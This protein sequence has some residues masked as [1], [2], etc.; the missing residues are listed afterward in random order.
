MKS[1]S[2]GVRHDYKDSDSPERPPLIPFSMNR[3]GLHWFVLGLAI[4]LVAVSLML[5]SE[6]NESMVMDETDAELSPPRFELALLA[7]GA[8]T[9]LALPPP[10]NSTGVGQ[11]LRPEQ[12]ERNALLAQGELINLSVRNGDSLDRMFRRNNL[13]ISD[14]AEMVDLP[15]GGRN[16][17]RINPGDKLEI[18]RS[19]NRVL[20]LSRELS[21]SQRLWIKR[22]DE[23]FVA[24]V[25]DLE[26]ELRSAG[27]HGE[28]K[29]TL[30]EAAVEAGLNSAVIDLLA[31]TFEWDIDFSQEVRSGDSFTV[32][33]EEFW[34]DGVRMRTGN[35]IA[36]EYVNRGRTYRAAR[37]VDAEGNS[38]LFTPEGMNV[39][40]AFLRYPIDFTRISSNFNPNRR[41]PI[42]NTIRAHRGVDLAAATGTPVRAAGDGR[43]VARG[44]NGSYGNRVEIQHGGGITTLYAHLNSYGQFRVGDRVSQGDL[45]GFV[46]MTGGATGPHLH[47]EYRLNG[48]HLNPRTVDLPEAEPIAQQY[49]ADFET[50][51]A[52]LWRQ[53]D[54]YQGT[55]FAHGGD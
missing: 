50:S 25:I 27:T 54:L 26:M 34:R 4:P 17:A 44:A 36:A 48:V 31:R 12:I 2:G 40:R 24:E 6:P 18:I 7:P 46:G 49:L 9:P 14:L 20:A 23:S 3:R 22:V 53:L 47:Y 55:L 37:Y 32:I 30:W 11:L 33:Y 43:I 28:V 19:G 29:S 41:H 10:A 5:F 38:D 42:L 52:S 15:E 45:I 35:I 51:T 13:S 39:E 8:R 16:L 1:Y 21:Q